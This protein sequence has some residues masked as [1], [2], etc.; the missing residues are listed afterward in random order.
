MIPCSIDISFL[1]VCLLIDDKL[2]HNIVKV[3]AEPRP[4]N[5]RVP[6][7]NK[8]KRRRQLAVNKDK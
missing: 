5:G 4:Q 2:R 3:A 8:E 1:C 7:I 6:G